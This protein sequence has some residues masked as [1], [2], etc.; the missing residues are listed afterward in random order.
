MATLTLSPPGDTDVKMEFKPSL[1][2]PASEEA[3]KNYESSSELSDLE[4]DGDNNGEI[5]PDHY[6]EGGKI[7]VFTP[8][9]FVILT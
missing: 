5:V 7:P 6:Y 2:P 8:V 1:T 9:G 4:I 3:D